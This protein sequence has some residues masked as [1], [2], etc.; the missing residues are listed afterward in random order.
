MSRNNIEFNYENFH[1]FYHFLNNDIAKLYCEDL[2]SIS[3]VIKSDMYNIFYENKIEKNF[4]KL[5]EKNKLSAINN[6][7]IN[8]KIEPAD[9]YLEENENDEEIEITLAIKKHT[10]NNAPF[11]SFSAYKYTLDL[12]EFDHLILENGL[13]ESLSKIKENL[14]AEPQYRKISMKNKVNNF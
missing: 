10:I 12:F 4:I 1:V 9:N 2:L 13:S 3:Y 8:L 5:P 11:Y 6:L 14:N 7:F